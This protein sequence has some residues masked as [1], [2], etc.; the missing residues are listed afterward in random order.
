MRETKNSTA[1]GFYSGKFVMDFF[2]FAP[3]VRPTPAS[4]NYEELTLD[5]EPMYLDD[6]TK[7]A[8]THRIE[9]S[10]E[11]AYIFLT[12][13]NLADGITLDSCKYYASRIAEKIYDGRA[14][15]QKAEPK[16]KAEGIFTILDSLE[17][18]KGTVK[19]CV[20]SAGNIIGSC[21][22]VIRNFSPKSI[23]ERLFKNL[24]HMLSD[25]TSVISSLHYEDQPTLFKIIAD[26]LKTAVL[27]T[28]PRV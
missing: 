5:Q 18:L 14:I 15:I 13:L 26:V 1:A 23:P 28:P 7:E 16:T 17:Y 25:T 2:F 10:Y 8:L 4:F 21:K 3:A 20:D 11:A 24:F 27:N 12:S 6:G 9:N 22:Y 19:Y